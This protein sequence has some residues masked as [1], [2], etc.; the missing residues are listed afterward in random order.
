MK[1]LFLWLFSI[2]AVIAIGFFVTAYYL[3]KNWQPLLEEQLKLA[4]IN[5][6]DSLYRIEYKSLDVNPLNGNLKLIDFKLIPVMRVYEKLKLL[7]EAPDNLYKLEVDALVIR[8]ANAKEAVETKRLQIENIIIAHPQLTI[9]N[10]KQSYNDTV[11]VA[12][13]RKEPYELIKD[14][15]RELRIKNIALNDINFTFINKNETKEKITSLKNLDINVHDILIDSLSILDKSRIYYTKDI[16][17]HIKNY[18]VATPDSLYYVKVNDLNFS[19]LK[20]ELIINKVQYSPRF[21]KI[22]FYKRVGYAK[23]RFDLTF[24]N[25]IV[26]DINF[27]LFL[28]QQ[29][30]YAQTVNIS[31][32]KVDV[33]NNNAYPKRR[34]NK[35]GKFPHQQLLRVALDMRI[36][37]I[38]LTNLDISYSE[39]D[40][41]SKRTGRIDFKNTSGTITNVA[42]DAAS[43]ARNSIMKA[44]LKSMVFG[45]ARL[46]LNLKFYMKSK[47][48]AFDYSG[49]LYA[50]N[51]NIINNIITPLGMA[52]IKSADVKKLSF[53]ANADQYKAKG[54]M[55]FYYNDLKVSI[56]K[57]DEE[58]NFKKQGLISTI[59]NKF[60]IKE[61]NPTKK[62]EF[63]EGNISYS[64]P[65]FAS[66]F[67]YLWQSLFTG[68]KESVGVSQ[69]RESK[70]KQKAKDV[71]I[72]VND[73][74]QA[75]ADIKEKLQENKA[76]RLERKEERKEKKEEKEKIKE[77]EKGK[78]TII[79]K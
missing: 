45:K 72:L 60:I 59:A 73:V 67:N 48:G 29:K 77:I 65:V 69:E 4:V 17:I 41:K 62:G 51:G 10:D 50:F 2:I 42:N 64:R 9:I 6:T 38:K 24:N 46:N 71:G 15:F 37:V 47:V 25:I 28:K 43:L 18:R 68:I 54:K 7:Q 70:L 36:A 13:K 19:T 57:R 44:N 32:A 49:T 3:K 76:E 61:H 52:E 21:N 63:T 58:G 34:T 35:T 8:D 75:V 16:Q 11:A 26:R 74:K 55:Q 31:N 79:I 22:N 12:T 39:Y 20:N 40:A 78:D 56:L 33:Y 30:L 5:S 23:D 27:D 66:F 53:Y 1:K 14:I